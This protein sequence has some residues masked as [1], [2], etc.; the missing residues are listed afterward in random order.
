MTSILDISK[1]KVYFDGIFSKP[2]LAHPEGVAMGSDGTIYCGTEN[3]D[4]LKIK[5]DK[6]AL[7]KLA[8][9]NGF[10][11]GIAIDSEEN[12]FACEMK[13]AS[14][15]KYNKKE[16]SF[17]E[18]AKGPKIPNYPVIDEKR[19][20]LYVSDSVGFDEKGIGVYKFDL[21]TGIGVL[22][23]LNYLILQ[24]VCVYLLMANICM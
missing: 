19:N 20:N 22:V 11:L 3:G 5:K 9:S 4:I 16:N 17:R 6:S 18:F 10:I 23:L 24:M 8:T 15:Y 14:I 2:K 13:E 7:E 12:I 21:D 1:A